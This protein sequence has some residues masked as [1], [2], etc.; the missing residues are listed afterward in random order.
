MDELPNNGTRARILDAAEELFA[1]RGYAA[2]KLRDIASA[3][4]LRH[5]SLYYYVPG[6]KEQLYVEVMERTFVRHRVG[7]EQAIAQAGDDLRAQMHAVAQWLVTQPPLDITRMQ[8]ADMPVLD[9][10]HANQLMKLAYDSLRTPVVGAIDRGVKTG[11]IAVPD[12]D[13]A[14]M[15]LISLLQSVHSIPVAYRTIP[16]ERLGQQLTDMLFDGWRTR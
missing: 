4:G 9:P 1:T 16:T 11:R 15:G 3:V 12:L 6:G 2:V 7:L 14:A 5:A 8:Y 13:I 10:T